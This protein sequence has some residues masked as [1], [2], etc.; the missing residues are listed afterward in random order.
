MRHACVS[1]W[2]QGREANCGQDDQGAAF[3]T[4]AQSGFSTILE[5]TSEGKESREARY[6]MRGDGRIYQR[7]RSPFYWCEYWLRGEQ[8][9]ESTGTVDKKAAQKFLSRKLK[10]VHADQIGAKTFI[11]PQQERVTVDSLLDS[12]ESDYKLRGKWSTKVNSNVKPL[13]EYFGDWRAVDVTSDAVSKYI[14]GLREQEYSAATCNRRTQL[15]GQAYKLAVRTKKLNAAPFIPRLSEVGN[16]RQ[17]FFEIESLEIIVEN[18]PE[19]LRDFIR[20][21]HLI[22]WRKG[23]LQSL[24]WTDVADDVI[25][26]RAKHSKTRKPESVPLEGELRDM[27]ERR[28][29]AA[30]WQS[31]ERQAYFSE[32]VFHN[33]GQPVGDFRKAWATAC[34]A[35]GVGKFVCRT[36]DAE[37]DENRT[38]SKCGQTWWKEDL[39]YVGAIF[40]DFRR[41][42]ARNLVRAGVPVP[43]A[44]KITG[45]RTDSMFRRYA[46]V[47]E[48]QKREAL[49]RAQAYLSATA[50]R[51]QKVV[52]MRAGR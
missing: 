41:T 51:K 8:Y 2:Q 40:H 52:A 17:G 5:D 19:Y 30:V 6:S 47:S 4:G 38:C 23:S 7:K 32:Y 14:E 33:Q 1:R 31:E 25:Y 11:S 26:L 36:C 9:R 39:K 13:R 35:A 24:R 42:A 29:A 16:E 28:R 37:V 21:D 34:V 46:I 20:C 12:L 18:L 45:H 15:L 22:G 50:Q 27:I 10:E 49:A 48:D 43:V 44:M 3:G